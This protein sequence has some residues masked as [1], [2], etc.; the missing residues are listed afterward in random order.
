LGGRRRDGREQDN[1]GENGE[2]NANRTAPN[3]QD[4]E[5]NAA[6]ARLAYAP[7]GAN[8]FR[9]TYEHL[10]RSVATEGFERALGGDARSRRVR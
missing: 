1:Q 9:L 3:P 8:R 6:M 4:W 7:G 2:A 5:S 10:D